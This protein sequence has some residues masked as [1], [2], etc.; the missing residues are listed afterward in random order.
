MILF[1][2]VYTC[3]IVNTYM[4]CS[5]FNF[6][7]ILP[8]VFKTLLYRDKSAIDHGLLKL[9]INSLAL[10]EQFTFP[11]T[12]LTFTFCLLVSSADNLCK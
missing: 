8:I 3:C 5:E 4:F 11:K 9:F 6:P 10:N 1:F 2:I 12:M 7:W